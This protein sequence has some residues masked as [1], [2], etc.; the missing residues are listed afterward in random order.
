MAFSIERNLQARLTKAEKRIE[1]L[2]NLLD[3]EQ[4][5]RKTVEGAAITA[6]KML[7]AAGLSLHVIK[8][9]TGIDLAE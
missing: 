4:D 2:E 8:G 1:E 9:C 6:A 5:R 7:R 3:H